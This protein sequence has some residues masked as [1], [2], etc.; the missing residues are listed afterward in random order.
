MYRDQPHPGSF[1]AAGDVGSVEALIVPAQAHL[2]RDGQVRGGNNGL[3]E[4]E[5]DVGNSHQGR[6]GKAVGNPLG[7]TAEIEIN[8]VGT[9]IGGDFRAAHEP[10]GLAAGELD[11]VRQST[12]RGEL[13]HHLPLARGQGSACDHFRYDHACAEAGGK[14]T[15]RPVGDPRHRCEEGAIS[16]RQVTNAYF[17][18]IKRQS[19]ASKLYKVTIL[20]TD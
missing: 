10:F 7:W 8:H 6:P 12:G 11:D 3:D 1:G 17:A 2:D 4:R 5:R 16:D 19:S 20:V 14:I 15:H 13:A 9:G 18:G